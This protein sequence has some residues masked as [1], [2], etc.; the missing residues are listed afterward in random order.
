MA[1]SIDAEEV[2][3]RRDEAML[4]GDGDETG[5]EDE[6][7]VKFQA[8]LSRIATSGVTIQSQQ[9]GDED[10]CLQDKV[11]ILTQ[12]FSEK[13]A[14]FLERFHRVLH[15]DDLPCFSHLSHIYEVEF[16]MGEVTKMSNAKASKI[17]KRNRR[18]EALKKLESEG[19]YFSDE[20]MRSR[21]PLMFEHYIGQY[22]TDEE[23]LKMKGEIDQSDLKLSTILTEFM[24]ESDIKLLHQMQKED[25]EM[26]EEEEEEEEEDDDEDEDEE[27]NSGMEQDSNEVIAENDLPS[28]STDVSTSQQGSSPKRKVKIIPEEERE[29]LRQEFRHHMQE[30]FLKGADK[31]FDYSQVDNNVEYD[32]LDIRGRDEEENYF[33]KE[34]PCEAIDITDSDSEDGCKVRAKGSNLQEDDDRIE[35]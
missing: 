24:E 12:L 19:E 11:H 1:A 34:E 4:S 33:D 3:I 21:D 22:L 14:I 29:L 13:P 5:E 9:R 35:R 6:M 16:Y 8:M 27:E 2:N 10:M 20:Q 7:E 30:K 23:R 15:T 28:T 31:D 26:I 32:S 25:E 18:Y 17:Q